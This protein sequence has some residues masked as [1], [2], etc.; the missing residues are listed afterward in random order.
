MGAGLYETTRVSDGAVLHGERHLERITSS[1]HALGLP[2]PE[3]AAFAAAIAAAT[4]S[5]EVVR[6]RL[7]RA[8]MGGFVCWPP[9]A[10]RRSHPTCCG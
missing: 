6:V 4:G 9:S 3:R 10:V 7:H 2:A 5:G 1:A 8:S